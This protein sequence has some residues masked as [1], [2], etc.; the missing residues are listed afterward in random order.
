MNPRLTAPST[1]R[2]SRFNHSDQLH[3]IPSNN[4]FHTHSG[5]PFEARHSERMRRWRATTKP[6]DTKRERSPLWGSDTPQAFGGGSPIT[7][8]VCRVA[9]QDRRVV[10]SFWTT[11]PWRGSQRAKRAGGGESSRTP[12]PPRRF[13]PHGLPPQGGKDR[14]HRTTPRYEPSGTSRVRSPLWGSQ[15]PEAF[16]WGCRRTPRHHAWLLRP[17]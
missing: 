9:R 12:H 10:G 7:P 6:S 3:P 13:A 5:A 15:T 17:G 4:L 1:P 8:L 11:P 14:R 16:C 2:R